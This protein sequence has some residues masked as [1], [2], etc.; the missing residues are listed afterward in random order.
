MES[1]IITKKQISKALQTNT[2]GLKFANKSLQRKFEKNKKLIE[3][4]RA[5]E[6]NIRKRNAKKLAMQQIPET[7]L[8]ASADLSAQPDSELISAI[9][10]LGITAAD[11]IDC[12]VDHVRALRLVSEAERIKATHIHNKAM[13]EDIAVQPPTPRTISVNL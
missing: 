6:E 4:K 13:R 3:K 9:I 1:K 10:G 7:D 8:P 2:T 5:V 11:L 12:K